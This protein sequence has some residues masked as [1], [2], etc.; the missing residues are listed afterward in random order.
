MGLMDKVKAQA[1]IGLAKA[2]EATKAG[3]EKLDQVNAKHKADGLLHD[4][5]AAVYAEHVGRGTEAT[6]ADIE[7]LERVNRTLAL[8]D[9]PAREQSHLRQIETLVIAPSQRLDVLAERHV[10]ELPRPVRTMLAAIGVVPRNT[11]RR[12]RAAG[13]VAR[14]A[15]LASYLLFE[16]GYTGELIQLGLADVLARRTEVLAFLLG[17]PPQDTARSG[18]DRAG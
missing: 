8:L 2:S 3:Q 12:R 9:A 5:G 1:E 11:S 14:G 17:T 10:H 4:L 18:Q 6:T 7:R 15:T 13:A 16:R